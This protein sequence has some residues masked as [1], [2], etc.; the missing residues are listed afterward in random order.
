MLFQQQILGKGGGEQVVD[1]CWADEP[2]EDQSKWSCTLFE[3][4]FLD[5]AI[6]PSIENV[7][8]FS[9]EEVCSQYTKFELTRAMTSSGKGCVHIRCCYSNKC[10]VRKSAN[11]SWIVAGADEPE[12]DRSKWSCTLFEPFYVD[13][14]DDNDDAQTVRF[15]HIQ[16]GCYAC[17]WREA[18][19]CDLCL[20]AGSPMPEKDQCDVYTIIEWES[21]LVLPPKDEAFTIENMTLPRFAVL[22]SNFNDKCLHYIHEDGEVHGFLQFSGEQVS[23]QYSKYELEKANTSSNGN[24]LVHIK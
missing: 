23:S 7:L 8:R 3:V 16:L 12:E 24:V 22:K 10:F 17:L 15:H 2:E 4:L 18:T 9:A 14:D 1:R 13:N 21:L 20:C 6:H 5:D 11:D 19:P